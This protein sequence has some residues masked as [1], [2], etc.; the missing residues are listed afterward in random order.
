MKQCDVCGEGTFHIIQQEKTVEYKGH[1]KNISLN[2]DECDVCGA[3]SGETDYLR[4]HKRAVN[5]FKK[6]VDGLL[7]ATDVKTIREK[8]DITQKKAGKLFGGGPVAF[9]KYE[10]DDVIQSE[11]MDK[12]LKVAY[13]FGAVYRYLEKLVDSNNQSFSWSAPT[14]IGLEVV[15]KNLTGGTKKPPKTIKIGLI[16]DYVDAA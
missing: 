5:A 9:S 16:K 15:D 8:L 6:E 2:F 11:P 7:S 14:T 12:L 13:Q 3:D 10:N 1:K 4:D